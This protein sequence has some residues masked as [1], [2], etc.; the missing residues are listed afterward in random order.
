MV[1]EAE[2]ID[3]GYGEALVVRQLA[4]SIEPGSIIA[5]IGA[6]GSGKST[7][8]KALA[9]LLKPESGTVLLDGKPLRDWSRASLA[10][11]LALL[12]QVHGLPEDLTVRDLVAYGRFPHRRSPGNNNSKDQAAVDKALR[13]TNMQAF[14]ERQLTRLS[15]G[16]RQR[17]WLALSLA[18][19]P[20]ILLLDEPTTFLDIRY[21]FEVLDLVQELNRNLG[22]TVVMVLHDLNHA[23]RYAQ[24]II[25]IR[26]GRIL[27][28]GSPEAVITGPVLREV[29]GIEGIVTQECGYPHLIPT[30]RILEA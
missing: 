18:Q 12:P 23:A 24:R 28:D 2:Q 9:R 30:G 8:L 29:F 13:L 11:N 26:S 10:R 5:I 22:L 16:E 25:A 7:I 15:G 4:L 14:L 21:Q 17:A 20:S 6:N 3:V 27:A 19:E 1:L